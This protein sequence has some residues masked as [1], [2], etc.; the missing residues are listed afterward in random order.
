MSDDLAIVL[1][2]G[3]YT[4]LGPAIRFPVLAAEEL[5]YRSTAVEYPP[6]AVRVRDVP[7]IV[8][9]ARVQ[10][11]D[12]IDSVPV[13]RA[14]VIAKSMGTGVVVELAELLGDVRELAVV[15][16]TP[17]FGEPGIRD[18]AMR[19]GWRSLIVCGEADPYHDPAGVM[20]VADAL[21]AQV[22]ELPRADHALEVPGDVRAT[23]AGLGDV[24]VG[25]RSFL[26]T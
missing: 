8:E 13:H 7:T 4:P 25:V 2:G 22:I 15:W 14:V 26:A 17:L 5:R 3:G 6:E 24:A 10:V 18:R 1:P 21:D 16:V 19:S 9:A 23:I 12:A 11:A 20:A